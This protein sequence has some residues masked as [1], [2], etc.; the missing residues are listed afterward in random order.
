M[1]R[2]FKL[3]ITSLNTWS[4]GGRR[5]SSFK[6]FSKVS[7]SWSMQFNSGR[8][9]TM[10]VVNLVGAFCLKVTVYLIIASIHGSSVFV[11]GRLMLWIWGELIW[12]NIFLMEIIILVLA[13]LIQIPR[14]NLLSS[15]WVQLFPAPDAKKPHQRSSLW[16]PNIRTS[17]AVPDK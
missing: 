8:S 16:K 15:W 7:D 3:E 2:S 5:Y 12:P 14:R 6:A 11:K 9:L 17:C 13:F 10:A 1:L 4:E